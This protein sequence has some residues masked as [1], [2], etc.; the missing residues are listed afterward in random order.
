MFDGFSFDEVA[1]PLME[2]GDWWRWDVVGSG[3]GMMI[4]SFSLLL[5]L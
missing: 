3:E 5:I 4:N 2:V 1:D